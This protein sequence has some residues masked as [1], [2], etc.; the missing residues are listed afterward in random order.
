MTFVPHMRVSAI[1]TLPGSEIFS[2]GFAL[3]AQEPM[4]YATF[5]GDT[6]QNVIWDSLAQKVDDFFYSMNLSNRAVLRSLKVAPIGA[7]GKYTGSPVERAVNGSTGRAGG[8]SAGPHHPNQ[9][10]IACTLHTGVDL[11]RVKGRF[12]VPMP[13]IAPAADGWI[14]EAER[15]LRET[16]LQTLVNAVA[17]MPGWDTLQGDIRVVVASQGR[18]NKDGSV[19]LPPGNHEVTAVSVGRTLDTIRRRRNKLRELH[20]TLS[21]VDQS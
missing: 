15:D 2:F 12:Y 11:G 6:R 18:H 1:G 19:R 4:S 5:L 8:S 9:I 10:A 14:T 17:D 13:A 3:E 20:G 7:D 16:A 21:T